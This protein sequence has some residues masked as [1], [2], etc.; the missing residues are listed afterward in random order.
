[1][2]PL[3]IFSL[4]SGVVAVVRHYL[5]LELPSRRRLDTSAAYVPFVK[6]PPTSVTKPAPPPPFPTGRLERNVF[7]RLSAVLRQELDRHVMQFTDA[8]AEVLQQYVDLLGHIERTG[9]NWFARNGSRTW[10]TQHEVTS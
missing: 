6:P 8:D 5:P 9:D 2:T 4:A 7:D 1:M 10:S 3:D